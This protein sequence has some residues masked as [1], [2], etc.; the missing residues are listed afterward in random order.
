MKIINRSDFQTVEEIKL[1]R[2]GK[3]IGRIVRYKNKFYYLSPRTDEHFFVI[4]KG[5][6]IDT[7][8]FKSFITR[9][10]QT[11]LQRR[12]GVKVNLSGIIIHYKG[13][14]ENRYY[15]ADIDTWFENSQ[16]YGTANGKTGETY[17]QQKILPKKFMT[18]MGYD[19]D[20]WTANR[21]LKG[22]LN[23]WKNIK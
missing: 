21:V 23:K 8:L 14:R 1:N 22:G 5:F 11:E 18:I 13:V 16:N 9:K 6:G 17:G 19:A 12:L 2:G 20:D 15:F 10:F 4:Y 7:A 3:H